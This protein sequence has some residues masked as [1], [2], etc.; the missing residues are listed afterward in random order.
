[1]NQKGKTNRRAVS[2]QHCKWYSH[3]IS[4]I[5]IR[6]G[7]LAVPSSIGTKACAKR[8][9]IHTLAVNICAVNK[10]SWPG[11]KSDLC[12]EL[13]VCE[14]FNTPIV[15]LEKAGEYP[16]QIITKRTAKRQTPRSGLLTFVKFRNVPSQ[17]KQIPSHVC[18][19]MRLLTKIVALG[20]YLSRLSE[21]R[22]NRLYLKSRKNSHFTF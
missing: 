8:L 12:A 9:R 4:G 17:S 1:M 13:F 18:K 5:V 20:N 16:K 21:K 7:G 22:Y 2:P 15:K 14:Q 10:N 11:V 6:N 19:K 3:R